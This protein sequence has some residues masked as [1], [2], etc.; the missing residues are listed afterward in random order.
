MSEEK[1]YD[2]TGSPLYKMAQLCLG[3]AKVLF[4]GTRLPKTSRRANRKRE[5]YNRETKKLKRK[6]IDI[7]KARIYLLWNEGHKNLTGSELPPISQLDL[8]E[9]LKNYRASYDGEK[10]TITHRFGPGVGR[11]RK[12]VQKLKARVSI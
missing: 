2:V 10:I 1:K 12:E 6:R 11:L 5:R 4:G 8:K 7:G 3:M 9:Y